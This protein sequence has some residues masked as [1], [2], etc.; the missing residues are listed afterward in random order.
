MA[1]KDGM[2]ADVIEFLRKV[3]DADKKKTQP[4]KRITPQAAAALKRHYPGIPEEYLA[5]MKEVG[6]GSLRRFQ[7]MIYSGLC[8]PQSILGEDECDWLKKKGPILCFGD[9]FS[10]DMSG[11]LPE[12][13]WAIV[14]LW[15]D[16]LRVYPVK[17]SFG[18]YIRGKILMDV[19]S[20]TSVDAK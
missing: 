7:F 5:F 13:K 2:Y 4:R 16:D 1:R 10:G 3:E 6:W 18:Q 19:D 9:N 20:G 15:H 17:Q 14:E 8:T 12:K 11:F